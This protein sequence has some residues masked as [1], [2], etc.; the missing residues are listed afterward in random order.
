VERRCPYS[1]K[2]IYLEK[3]DEEKPVWPMLAVCDI[4]DHP[5][6]WEKQKKTISVLEKRSFQGGYRQA[7]TD[8]LTDGP[9]G[10]CVFD[11]DNDVADHQ[12]VNMAFGDNGESTAVL[13]MNAFTRSMSRKTVIS[14][15]LKLLVSLSYSIL[16]GPI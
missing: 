13:T 15:K 6:S 9:Y 7:L 12:T 16:Y 4:E 5:G 11:C 3:V 10:R 14:G 2:K 1:A 8:A